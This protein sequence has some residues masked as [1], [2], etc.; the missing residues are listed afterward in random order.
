MKKFLLL[1]LVT[2][3][4]VCGG[5]QKGGGLERVLTRSKGARGRGLVSRR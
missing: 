5:L 2:V 3:L 4:V 1:D